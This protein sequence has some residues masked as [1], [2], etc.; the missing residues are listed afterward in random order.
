MDAIFWR[1]WWSC[2]QTYLAVHHQVREESCHGIAACCE[3]FDEVALSQELGWCV[4]H[5]NQNS[6]SSSSSYIS[7]FMCKLGGKRL[8]FGG[9][10]FWELFCAGEYQCPVLNKVFTEYSH[11]V[12]VKTT[13]NVFSYEVNFQSFPP[14]S[15]LLFRIF[16][17]LLTLRVLCCNTHVLVNLMVMG[18][19]NV[20]QAIKELN[21]KTKNWQEL[22]TDEP[23]KREDLITIQ[24]RSFTAN[25]SDIFCTFNF[26]RYS[27]LLPFSLYI[28]SRPFLKSRA[29]VNDKRRPV[30]LW[31]LWALS[32]RI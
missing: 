10:C 28:K 12:A 26:M 19:G 25:S 32:I 17:Q 16:L 2:M 3:G 24:V 13:G 30:P 27:S 23:F 15:L 4:I 8:S 22:L 18:I 1:L 6:D 29:P 21:I 9:Q 11:I 31:M 14:D 5:V 20:V 7:C